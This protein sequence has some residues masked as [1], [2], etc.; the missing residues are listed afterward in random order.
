MEAWERVW[1]R[2]D[3]DRT[4]GE[5]LSKPHGHS[6]TSHGRATHICGRVIFAESKHGQDGN[7]T[8]P[9]DPGHVGSLKIELIDTPR[10]DSHGQLDEP[11][12]RVACPSESG[13][14]GFSANFEP[15]VKRSDFLSKN[16]A[17]ERE[18]TKNT[19]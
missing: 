2:L 7:P 17:L 18:S 6:W 15:Q 5:V 14:L 8:W 16:R 13:N 3:E 4:R 1:S 9:C 11:H 19:S 10:F 12:G